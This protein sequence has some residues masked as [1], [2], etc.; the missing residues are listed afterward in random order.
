ML[1]LLEASQ[2]HIMIGCSVISLLLMFFTTSLQFHSIGKKYALLKMEAGVAVLVICD[3]LARFYRADVIPMKLWVIE[4][5]YF[6]MFAMIL[7]DECF[8]NE[9]LVSLF[10]STRKFDRIPNRLALGFILPLIGLVPLILNPFTKLYFYF[11]EA[12]RYVRGPFFALSF[13][14]PVITL[15]IQISFVANYRSLV[16]RKIYIAILIHGS[17][18]VICGITQVFVPSLS[19]LN[20]SV[21]VSGVI[22]FWLALTDQNDE[23]AKAARTEFQTGLPNAYGYT[24]EVDKIILRGNILEYNAY[25]FDIVRMS[26]LNNKYGRRIGDE[27]L[28]KYAHAIQDFL[29]RD[30]IVGRLGGNYFVALVKKKNTEKFLEYLSGVPVEVEFNNKTEKI[31]VAAVAGAYEIKTKNISSGR[32]MGNTSAAVSYAKNI[33]KK[34]VIFMDDRLEDEFKKLRLLEEKTRKGIGRKEFEPYYQPKVNTQAGVMTGAEAL[35]R[36]KKDGRTIP[37]LE[38]V[39][40]ME[41]NGSICDLDF[42]VLDYVCRDIKEWMER[43]IE[44]VPVSVNFSRRNLGNEEFA[45]K[46]TETVEKYGIPR[47]LIQIEITETLDEYPMSLM[48]KVVEELRSAGMSVAIDDFGTGSSSIMLLKKVKFDV[49]K[50]DKFFVDLDNESD[51]QLLSNIITMADNLGIGVIAEGVEEAHTVNTLNEMGCFDI[52]GYYFDK[53]LEKNDF[54]KKLINK[55][56]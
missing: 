10:M 50:I 46:I 15:F 18:P 23:L 16:K 19:L 56:Y 21:W 9:Y 34:P 24:C 14:V 40:V 13:V 6:F 1:E 28:Y 55:R 8:F 41:R 49:M 22:L 31:K 36:W 47:K 3:A 4:T 30:E 27:I 51:K 52:Q 44:P 20:L 11:N 42:Y 2:T 53:P 39:P 54:E 26:L 7:I 45:T 35:V 32:I 33:A 48:A 12:N 29:E 38:F 37:P 17:S 43:G 25:Y 5:V